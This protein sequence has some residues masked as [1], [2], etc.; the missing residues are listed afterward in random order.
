MFNGWF[1]HLFA[2]MGI[3]L[4]FRSAFMVFTIAVCKELYD[5]AF[6]IPE[7]TWFKLFDSGVDILLTVVGGDIMRGWR[8]SERHQR[9]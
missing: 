1:L 9:L 6:V 5:W 3:Q 4:V 2:G 7:F 8:N